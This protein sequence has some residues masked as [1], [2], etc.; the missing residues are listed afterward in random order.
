MVHH[1]LSGLQSAAGHGDVLLF[2]GYELH[3]TVGIV[4]ENGSQ[5][6]VY[7]RQKILQD[8]VDVA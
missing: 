7:V 8:T 5:L 2:C 6:G 4:L 1:D 3:Y